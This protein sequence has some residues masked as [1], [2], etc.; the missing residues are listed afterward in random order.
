MK[1]LKNVEESVHQQSIILDKLII[2]R[3]LSRRQQPQLSINGTHLLNVP[4]RRYLSLSLSHSEEQSN[5]EEPG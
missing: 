4:H 3:H 1:I 5:L 2:I